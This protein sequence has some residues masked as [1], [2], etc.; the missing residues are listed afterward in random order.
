MVLATF[1]FSA[2]YLGR[3]LLRDRHHP[4]L[5]ALIGGAIVIVALQIPWLNVVVWL[6]MVFF[7]LGAQL[8]AIHHQ[9]PWHRE[10]APT[11]DVSGRSTEPVTPMAPPRA[12]TPPT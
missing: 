10:A 11:L 1:V 8:L 9:R 12:E 5:M 7:G 6:A 4:V 3:L 2:Y